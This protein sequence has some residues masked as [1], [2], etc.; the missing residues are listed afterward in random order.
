MDDGSDQDY[1]SHIMVWQLPVVTE[2]PSEVPRPPT[3]EPR[4]VAAS[5]ADRSSRASSSLDL[6]PTPGSGIMTA[7]SE[8]DLE[9]ASEHTLEEGPPSKESSSE[10]PQPPV[11]LTKWSAD[12][13][14]MLDHGSLPQEAL[15]AA[16]EVASETSERPIP[17]P[18]EDF[19]QAPKSATNLA[20]EGD[21]NRKKGAA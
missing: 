20:K 8:S 9:T 19:T 5:E 10:P 21:E 11:S 12:V 1:D 16:S 17:S 14:S 13:E 7:D 3:S 18:L 2:N 15:E 4:S 6:G